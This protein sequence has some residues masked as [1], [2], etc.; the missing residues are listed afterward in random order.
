MKPPWIEYPDYPP[1]C[2]GWRMGPGE[3]Y[4]DNWHQY[5]NKLDENELKEYFNKYIPPKEW[6]HLKGQTIG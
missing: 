1:G 3:D 5:I 6:E 2:L 4:I